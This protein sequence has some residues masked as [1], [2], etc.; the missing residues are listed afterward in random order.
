[1]NLTDNYETQS[2]CK[3]DYKINQNNWIVSLWKMWQSIVIGL[4]CNFEN[5]YNSWMCLLKIKLQ[6][7][8][9]SPF[10]WENKFYHTKQKK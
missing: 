7:V 2:G 9:I 10:Y 1:M 3:K 4:H 8:T 6:V 5:R